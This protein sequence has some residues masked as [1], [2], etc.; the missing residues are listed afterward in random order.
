MHDKYNSLVEGVVFCRRG[1]YDYENETIILANC[2]GDITRLVRKWYTGTPNYG[3]MLKQNPLKYNADILP[4]FYSKNNS[5]VGG[6]PKPV[7]SVSY[8]N[9]NGILNHMNYQTQSFSEG[10]AYVNSYNGNLTT[11]FS[12][13]GTI[14]GKLPFGLDLVYN[15]ND[16]VLN[17]DYGYGLGYKLSLHQMIKEQPVGDKTY[18]EYSDEDGTL[19]YFLNQK[20]TFDDQ[21]YN[22]INTENIYYDEDGLDMTIT[23]NSNDYILKD[24]NG[25]IKKFIKNG[26]IAYLSEIEDISGNKNIITYSSGNVITKIV[27][28]NDSEVNITYTEST[29]TITSPDKMVI[30]NYS[31]NKIVN[32][33][34]LL[35]TT[36]FEYNDNN[37]ITKITDINGLKMTYEYYDQKP[38]KVKKVSHYGLEDVPGEYFDVLYGFDS[39]TIIDSKGNAKNIIFN[40]QGSIVSI[41]GLKDKEDINNAYGISQINGTNDG[42]NPG[43]NNKLL[44]TE[45][46]LKYVKNL[47]TN[48]SFE[49]NVNYFPGGS[50]STTTISDEEANTGLKSLKIVSHT[51]DDQIIAYNS[52]TAY[53]K[54]KYYTFSCYV[55]STNK[56]RLQLRY[57][58][59]DDQV[60]EAYS[61]IIEPS[62]EFERHDVTI[63]Y[64]EDA[65]SGLFLRFNIMEVGTAYVDD[66]QLEEGEVANNY[67]LIE[68]SDFSNGYSDWNVSA[69]DINTGDELAVAD[70]FEIVTLNN[71]NK[72]LKTKLNPA[73]AYSMEK[74]F[75]ISGKGGDVF[76]ISFWY[77]NQGIDSNLSEYYGSRAYVSF[78][79]INQDD[80]HCGIPS[81]L[82]NINDEAWQ[83]VSNDFMAEKDYRSITIGIYHEYTANDFYI[84]NMSLFK[85][86]RNVYYEYDEYGNVILENDLDNKN[87]NL[88]YDK[89]NNL[90][91]SIAP[92][93]NCDVFEYDNEISN[94]LLNGISD[95]GVS[96]RRIYDSNEN[97]IT[98]RI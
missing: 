22:T 30:L 35:G 95:L 79:Y 24:K 83:Y 71:G 62:E 94:H 28:A 43:Y 84:T 12:V 19:H 33:T 98:T 4:A 97:V 69:A 31:N 23:K 60:V 78:D 1:S 6:N 77:K 81:P 27:D 82:L 46:P 68:N 57:E 49:Q 40:S 65:N 74:T 3:I 9:Q 51:Y 20:T 90:I 26:N 91:K 63:Y 54:G 86:I 50:Y 5:I 64:P 53:Q 36:Y 58:D 76:N 17:N 29:I 10:T 66:I 41:S 45:I 87:S 21:G 88:S 73:Y 96:N 8:R 14:G 56:L 11:I 7:L 47:L 80:G 92:D 67:N 89:K 18:L 39:T 59:K 61:D 48:T 52:N 25:N 44:R 37:I 70:N 93:G 16:V 15:T 2:G 85:D 13:G 34:S 32:I 55:K 42:T 75:N 38:Y 72:A